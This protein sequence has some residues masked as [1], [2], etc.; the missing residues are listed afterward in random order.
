MQRTVEILLVLGILVNLLKGAD[1]ILRP[2]QQRWLQD[3]FELLVLKLDYTRPIDWYLKKSLINVFIVAEIVVVIVLLVI[4]FFLIEITKLRL[5]IYLILV[6][7]HA[8]SPLFYSINMEPDPN[9]PERLWD[10][11]YRLAEKLIQWVE[12]SGTFL[13]Q[14][15]RLLLLILLVGAHILLPYLLFILSD[16]S[17]MKFSKE[18]RIL[19]LFIL[20]PLFIFFMRY[21]IGPFN[22]I[23]VIGLPAILVV[24]FTVILIPIEL[25]IRLLRGI[26]WRIVEYNKGAFAAIVLLITIALGAIEFYL[27]FQPPMSTTPV[28]SAPSQTPQP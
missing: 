11:N 3:K 1:L 9:K 22:N 28:V 16:V 15:V 14:I 24:L 17:L 13:Q 2:H 19:F 10:I 20:V 18:L 21:Y 23:L 6:G 7:W 27:K 5:L 26:V 25:L 12:K 4:P 8:L